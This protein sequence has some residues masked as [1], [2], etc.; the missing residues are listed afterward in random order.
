M[1]VWS[2]KN[3]WMSMGPTMYG[4]KDGFPIFNLPIYLD[5]YEARL[6]A[7][8]GVVK[9]STVSL[10]PSSKLLQRVL[11]IQCRG[12]FYQDQDQFQV[13]FEF[14][15]NALF[16]QFKTQV[17]WNV[18]SLQ[19]QITMGVNPMIYNAADY[20]SSTFDSLSNTLTI[21]FKKPAT[22]KSTEYLDFYF[23]VSV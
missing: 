8:E 21:L 9:W 23:N 5:K 4:S 22:I 2:N 16:E 6:V 14:V 20:L 15:P 17:V 12:L 7:S 1:K 18:S 10:K 3:V 13:Q 19:G 11:N